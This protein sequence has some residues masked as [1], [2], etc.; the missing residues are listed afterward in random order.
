MAKGGASE[1]SG[2]GKTFESL[3][4]PKYR[5]LW[6]GSLTSFAALQMTQV[7]RPWLAYELSDS[8][9]VLGVIA[10]FQG[11]PM[12]IAAPLG[13]LAADRLSKRLVLYASTGVLMATAMVMA[14]I[15]WLDWVQVWHL[16]V[17]S[18]IHGLT[19]PFNQPVRQSFIP[20][21]VPRS[22]AANALALNASGRNLNQILGPALA[23]ILLAIDPPIC[24]AVIAGL[25]VVTIVLS[26]RLPLGAPSR[27][28]DRSPG[29]DLVYGMRYIWADTT[30]RTLVILALAAVTLGFPYQQLLTVFQQD[31]FHVGPTGLGFMVS[32]LGLGAL[33]SSLVVASFSRLTYRGFPQLIAGIAF[34][35]A[36]IG[37]A[38]SPSI[39]FAL[40]MLF[41]TGFTSQAYTT[42]NSTLMLM[43]AEEEF[44]GRVASVNMMTRSAM[45]IVVLPFGA[46]VDAFGAPATVS[47][48]G[49]ALAVT[50]VVI[51]L[52]KPTL[53]QARSTAGGEGPPRRH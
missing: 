20:L 36:L 35:V 9:L 39:W 45:P 4:N 10:A 26:L 37:F 16:A 11:I 17:L 23:G 34:G 46:L 48:A 50:I 30:L 5:L 19:V 47:V 38:Q 49:A 18:L 27:K 12:L 33:T 21:L 53:W 14:V 24:F 32:A 51:G 7:A 40:P 2:W 28:S 44:Y 22:Q 52:I 8:A 41:T 43:N 6:A 42:M 31:V 3:S 29:K 25:H 1:A 15:V 13:G